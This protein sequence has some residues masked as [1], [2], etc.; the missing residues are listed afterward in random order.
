MPGGVVGGKQEREE[1]TLLPIR[2]PQTVFILREQ[3]LAV[4]NALICFPCPSPSSLRMECGPYALVLG[5]SLLPLVFFFFSLFFCT[6]TE[7]LLAVPN[8]DV[9]IHFEMALEGQW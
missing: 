8:V 1:R 4:T 5:L 7:S 3:D 6:L 2:D 9:N